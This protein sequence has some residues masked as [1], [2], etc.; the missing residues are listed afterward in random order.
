EESSP[1]HASD[2]D[3]RFDRRMRIVL[4]QDE[5]LEAEIANVFYLWVQFHPRQRP[6][7]PGKLLV[8]LFQMVPVK[9]EIAESVNEFA[10][11]EIADLRD[12]HREQRIRRD[13]ERHAQEEIGAALVELAAERVVAHIK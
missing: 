4:A 13:V 2:R 7:V 10:R 12:H 6:A 3:R 8:R 1:V 9:M 11:L 5:I